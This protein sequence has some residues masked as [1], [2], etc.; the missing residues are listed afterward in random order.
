M[1]EM[2]CFGFRSTIANPE[3][4]LFKHMMNALFSQPVTPALDFMYDVDLHKVRNKIILFLVVLDCRT[5]QTGLE[6]RSFSPPP[7]RAKNLMLV[8]RHIAGTRRCFCCKARPQFWLHLMCV[9]TLTERTCTVPVSLLFQGSVSE[10][11]V[12]LNMYITRCVERIFIKHGAVGLSTPLLM[13][14]SALYDNTDQCVSLMDHSGGIV[15]LPFD[16]R[17]RF[18]KLK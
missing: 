16:L 8:W 2:F 13:P 4:K 1:K 17:V 3:S 14:R 7:S 5:L 15:S 18:G 10:H 6:Q 11:L 9:T 12:Q